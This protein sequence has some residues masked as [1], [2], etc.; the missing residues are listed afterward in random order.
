MSEK[1]HRRAR[2]ALAQNDLAG[3]EHS[4]A[5]ALE[6]NA[7]DD[8]ALALSGEIRFKQ[9][10]PHEA[11]LFYLRA[12]NAA[13]QVHAHKARFLELASMGFPM[14]YSDELSSALTACLK[15]PDLASQLEN[16]FGLMA[17][18]P[19]FQ[20][21]FGFA[22][23]RKFDP[24]NNAF[25]AAIRDFRPL[26][27]PLFLE[28]IKAHLVYNPVFEQFMTQ[29]RR[30]LLEMLDAPNAPL[31][32]EE[33]TTLAAAI[34]HYAL[35]SEFILEVDEIERARI[36]S[37]RKSV[38]TAG[39]AEDACGVA[40]LACYV[41]LHTLGNAH[42][43]LALYENSEPLGSLVQ[44]HIGEPLLLAKTAAEIPSVTEISDPASL[45][46]REQYESFPYPRWKT[47]A[48]DRLLRE[49]QNDACSQRVE[50]PLRGKP[51][52]VRVAG[53]GTGYE[54]VMLAMIFPEAR[55]TAVDL[56]RAS[57]AYAAMKAREHNI[58]NVTFAQ[59]D[60][61]KLKDLELRYDYIAASGVL[62]HMENPFQG[63]SVLRGLLKPGGLMRIGLY[64]RIGRRAVSAAQDAIRRG[65]YAATREGMLRFRKDCPHL[66]DGATLNTLAGLK[67]Y[68]QLSMYRDLLFHVQEQ[69]F[70]I[71]EIAKMLSALGLSFEG[72][73][74]LPGVLGRYRARFPGDPNGTDLGNWWA[75]EQDN[76]ETFLS[77]YTFWCRPAA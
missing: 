63:W 24:A 54:A 13:P 53:C 69:R 8:V 46:V 14:R 10:R 30:R 22:A 12:V 49:W 56:S 72:F 32:L 41:P 70:D 44:A 31:T 40:V 73:H 3:A 17:S 37:L 64:S 16:W 77:M 29:V 57:L 21:A 76:P 15:T 61:L 4:V 48:R 62:H 47:I 50:A 60:L 68:Y 26:L 34:A 7:A 67:D 25:F 6:R 19:R 66:L 33:R 27:T 23:R 2:E 42:E 11:F 55:I 45:S 9:N 59:A 43:L 20:A 75:F 5:R 18:E 71:P 35:S 52:D 74:V 65:G 38:E 58:A 28:G 39:G 51:I 1:L 36:E